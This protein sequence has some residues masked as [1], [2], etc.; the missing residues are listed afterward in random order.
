[1]SFNAIIKTIGSA[2]ESRC[3][4]VDVRC[5]EGHELAPSID[6]SRREVWEVGS[7]SGSTVCIY[8]G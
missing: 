2:W 4:V 3:V 8:V 1:M 6:R 7:S 5:V